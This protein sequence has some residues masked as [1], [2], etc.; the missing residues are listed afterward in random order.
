MSRDSEG[1]YLDILPPN[2]NRTDCRTIPKPAVICVGF[3][4]ATFREAQTPLLRIGLVCGTYYITVQSRPSLPREEVEAEDGKAFVCELDD[5]LPLIK[6]IEFGRSNWV[7]FIRDSRGGHRLIYRNVVVRANCPIW[8]PLVEEAEL[9]VTRWLTL[10]M[11]EGLWNGREVEVSIAREEEFSVKR[12]EWETQ[13]H[14]HLRHLDIGIKFLGHITRDGNVVGYMTEVRVG[15][16]LMYSDMAAT[17]ELM[18]KALE[19]GVLYK[20]PH[21]QGFLVM[22]RGIVFVD[23]G[24]GVFPCRQEEWESRAEELNEA[25]GAVEDIFENLLALEAQGRGVILAVEHY[26]ETQAFIVPVIPTVIRVVLPDISGLTGIPILGWNAETS[27]VPF[28]DGHSWRSDLEFIISQIGRTDTRD[29]FRLTSSGRSGATSTSRESVPTNSHPAEPSAPYSTSR[30]QRADKK[31][32]RRFVIKVYGNV[33]P[34][35]RDIATSKVLLAPDAFEEDPALAGSLLSSMIVIGQPDGPRAVPRRAVSGRCFR[36]ESRRPRM[37]GI[38]SVL[39]ATDPHRHRGIPPLR[40]G[41]LR[42]RRRDIAGHRLDDRLHH[43]IEPQS[44]KFLLM[45]TSSLI[46]LITSLTFFS[47]TTIN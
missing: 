39:L 31:R 5:L 20:W 37:V 14:Y 30:I 45:R 32:T 16:E 46:P 36:P 35:R 41:Y 33:R 1:P 12:I 22:D 4:S 18:N 43:G 2:L 24:A 38:M 6:D 17:F 28:E 34:Y 47:D 26:G 8:V 44:S 29:W 10:T 15:R 40:R 25:W 21:P 11:F 27:G 23:M 9:R 3:S 13:S 42:L 19:N 7:H